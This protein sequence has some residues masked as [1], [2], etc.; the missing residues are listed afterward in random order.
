MSTREEPTSSSQTRGT[1]E[2]RAPA[3][4]TGHWDKYD[5]PCGV[6]PSVVSLSPSP[7]WALTGTSHTKTTKAK[8][9]APCHSPCKQLGVPSAFIVP[10]PALKL[11]H[12]HPVWHNSFGT[13]GYPSSQADQGCSR[14]FSSFL[15]SST[16]EAGVFLGH[17]GVLQAL[18]RMRKRI[19]MSNAMTQ[20]K[21]IATIAP[22]ERAAAMATVPQ[23]SVGPTARSHTWD[24]GA[25]IE[26]AASTCW[27]WQGTKGTVWCWRWDGD[28]ARLAV[29]Q[30]QSVS[31]AAHSCVP[32]CTTPQRSFLSGSPPP[33]GQ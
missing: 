12:K 33:A 17:E 13:A 11:Q 28:G 4:L 6:S 5:C 14:Y 7:L 8:D 10:G 16:S 23:E 29:G 26:H 32:G 2:G 31:S 27:H 3:V 25:V 15:D 21:E 22:V 19:R 24:A 9:C 30:C 1:L 18:Q 20:L